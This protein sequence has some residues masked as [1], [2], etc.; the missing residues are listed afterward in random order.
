MSLAKQLLGA[1]DFTGKTERSHSNLSSV[2][3]RTSFE[4][5][6]KILLH[7]ASKLVYEDYLTA[8]AFQYKVFRLA[9]FYITHLHLISY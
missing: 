3:W 1:R 2:M 5:S 7:M 6:L 9:I 4:A 8:Y